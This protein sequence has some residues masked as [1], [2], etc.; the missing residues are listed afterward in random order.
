MDLYKP[1]GTVIPTLKLFFS[2]ITTSGSDP[3]RLG[4][5]SYISIKRR[6]NNNIKIISTYRTCHSFI[7]YVGPTANIIQQW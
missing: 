2:G 7:K 5:W 1:G 4:R 6:D 3:H